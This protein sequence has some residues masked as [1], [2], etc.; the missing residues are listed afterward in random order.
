MDLCLVNLAES[1]TPGAWLPHPYL[2]LS[3]Q[4]TCRSGRRPYWRRPR[5]LTRCRGLYEYTW[6]AIGS[7]LAEPAEPDGSTRM[8][9]KMLSSVA[10]RA[11]EESFVQLHPKD[12]F[13]Q[14]VRW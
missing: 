2:Y 10:N 4:V 7:T 8:E 9:S 14:S 13:Y 1:V 3:G 6:Q 11:V 12:N 5:Q